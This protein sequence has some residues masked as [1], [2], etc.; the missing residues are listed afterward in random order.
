MADEGLLRNMLAGLTE[1]DLWSK[2]PYELVDIL[3]K[4]G[5]LD[6]EWKDYYLILYA[7][8][9]K[10]FVYRAF[11]ELKGCKYI[12][13]LACCNRDCELSF[14]DHREMMRTGSRIIC[15][16][17]RVSFIRHAV[18]TILEIKRNINLN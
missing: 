15:G 7:K 3:G 5:V 10:I 4:G 9:R 16:N 11:N 17:G 14:E 18:E 13:D 2:T 1:E 8:D 6:V 12:V